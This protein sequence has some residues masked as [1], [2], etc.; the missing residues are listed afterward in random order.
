MY[1][2]IHARMDA[3]MDALM[4]ALM[5]AWT[6]EWVD[7]I[8]KNVFMHVRKLFECHIIVNIWMQCKHLYNQNSIN[9]QTENS[10]TT[11]SNKFI[12]ADKFV[13]V[14]LLYLARNLWL[15][16]FSTATAKDPKSAFCL[17]KYILHCTPLGVSKICCFRGVHCSPCAVCTPLKRLFGGVHAHI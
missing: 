2:W 14:C 8:V 3:R 10:H 6:H 15:N 1:E 4:D 17:K 9:K 7:T 11:A 5:N 13:L 16:V 12:Y